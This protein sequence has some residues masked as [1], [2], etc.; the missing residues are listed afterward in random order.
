MKPLFLLTLLASGLLLAQSSG[1]LKPRR[2]VAGATITSAHD[3]AATIQLDKG[4]RYVGGERFILYG[5][6]DCELHIFVDADADHHIR[7]LYWVQFESYL[8]TK[9]QTYKYDS[10]QRTTIG[11][12]EF[13][14][15]LAPR[16][17]RDYQTRAGS[18]GE[19]MAAL[20]KRNGYQLPADAL[21]ARLVHLSDASKR[22]E[23]MIIY[24]EDLAPS[25]LTAAD[26]D[27]KGG[28]EAR[29]PKIA[30]GLLEHAKAGLKISK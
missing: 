1:D 21:W 26:L 22:R 10:T 24:V 25:G 18:D 11:G 19:R 3:P 16:S 5:V 30:E 2:A 8:P 6:A 15:D 28:S 17:Y 7:R 29:W 27:E 4:F 14:V 13:I 23:L 12:L 9:Q 20:L